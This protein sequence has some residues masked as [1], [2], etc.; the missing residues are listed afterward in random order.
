MVLH[1]IK[2]SATDSNW[3]LF[4]I[5]KA[6]P[7][8]LIFQNKILKR[9]DH[10]CQFCGFQSTEYLDVVNL[11]GN[12]RDN[13]S[14]NLATACS[15]CAQCFFL[16]AIGKGDFGGGTL[17]YLPEMTQNELNAFCHILFSA[18]V[19]G[20]EQVSQARNFYRSFKLRG[21]QIEKILGEGFSHPAVYGRVLIDANVKELAAVEKQ[22]LP[23][24]RLLP[25]FSRFTLQL[26]AWS[27]QALEEL[28]YD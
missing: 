15:F 10:T 28:S 27:Q 9:D 14:S 6:D 21:Q 24:L 4:M 18:M 3:R 2:L 7:A 19:N 8:F 25:D 16:E 22:L 20:S 17:I 12:Y 5:R 1:D 23:N 13:C 11:D 26:K